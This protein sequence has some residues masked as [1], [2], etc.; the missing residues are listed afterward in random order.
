M[1]KLR[2]EELAVE[3]F[4]TSP[5]AAVRGTVVA[6]TGNIELG[7]YNTTSGEYSAFATCGSGGAGCTDNTAHADCT[8]DDGGTRHGITCD[9]TCIKGATDC[10][11]CA[12][13]ASCDLQYG[14]SGT[15]FDMQ[16]C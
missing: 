8:V 14:C 5:R 13:A 16:A 11:T 12:P 2:L 10:G 7:C 15:S 6:Y 9:V 3:S 1:K 4:V